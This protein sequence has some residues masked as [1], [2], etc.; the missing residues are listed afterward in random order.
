MDS[1]STQH[2]KDSYILT[3]QKIAAGSKPASH[4]KNVYRGCLVMDKILEARVVL[5]PL[6]IILSSNQRDLIKKLFSCS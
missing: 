1:A 2:Q 6:I 4:L 5:P 3:L